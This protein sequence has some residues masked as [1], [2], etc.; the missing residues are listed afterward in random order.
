MAMLTEFSLTLARKKA[1]HPEASAIVTRLFSRVVAVVRKN[2][3]FASRT[4][5]PS[6]KNTATFILTEMLSGIHVADTKVM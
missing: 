4:V 5:H 1:M 2:I 3:I 6:Y